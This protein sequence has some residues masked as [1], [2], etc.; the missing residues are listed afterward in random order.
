MS[1]ARPRK[2]LVH[3]IVS[4][5]V[6]AAIFAL[7]L[8]RVPFSAIGAALR[9]ADFGWFLAL[10][11]PN[12]VFFFL[13]DTFVLTVVVRWFHGGVPYRE[14]LPVRAVSYVVGFFN[15]NLGRGALAAVSQPAAARAVSGV[16]QHGPV[17]RAHRVHAAGV[18]GDA[19]TARTARGGLAESAR[20]RGRRGGALALRPV[21]ARAARLV[22]L[23]HVPPRHTGAL[24]DDRAVAC[25]DVFRVARP[26]LLRGSRLRHPHSVSTDAHVPARDLHDRRAADYRGPSRQY[27]SSMD[28]SSARTQRPRS[29]SRSASPHI[30]CSRSRA[31][32]SA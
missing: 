17:P 30:S 8:G 5:L 25:A 18:M 27:A 29:C 4:I 1:I 7:I 28:S 23:A 15:T 12:A 14:L 24:R 22:D 11:I 3:Q 21:A 19:R 9:D 26:A 2:R 13:W 31:L 16:G 32:S 20:R 10:M 6:T